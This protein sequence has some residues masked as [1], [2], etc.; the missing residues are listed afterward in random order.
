MVIL[1]METEQ[2]EDSSLYCNIIKINTFLQLINFQN[3]WN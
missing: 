1:G 3:D 2:K